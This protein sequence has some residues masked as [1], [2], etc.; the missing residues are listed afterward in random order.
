[1]T[2]A[3]AATA[4]TP[5]ADG[6]SLL[7]KITRYN[8]TGLT[9]LPPMT[10]SYLADVPGQKGWGTG[11]PDVPVSFLFKESTATG[12]NTDDHG[13]QIAD[14]NRDGLPDLIQGFRSTCG[15]TPTRKAWL[16]TGTTWQLAPTGTWV[17]PEDFVIHHCGHEEYETGLRL[18]DIN[19][20][21]FLDL[22]QSL[23]DQ[24][25]GVTRRVWL[26]TGTTWGALEPSGKWALPESFAVLESNSST[27]ISSRDIGVRFGDV[28]GDGLVDLVRGW[29]I[30]SGANSRVVYLLDPTRGWVLASGWT[31]PLNFVIHVYGG[32]DAATGTNLIDVNGDGMAD[33][34]RSV[35]YEGTVQKLLYL[36]TG[37][38]F[39]QVTDW[40]IPDIFGDVTNTQN[41]SKGD[42]DSDDY[43]VRFADVN[44]DG[45]VDMVVARNWEGS[46]P[47][48]SAPP[49]TCQR[50]LLHRGG[51]GWIEDP[52]WAST[53][54]S[55]YFFIEH[56][57]G[58][59]DY[60]DGVRLT[61]IDGNGT[62][63]LIK[64]M[65]GYRGGTPE[66]RMNSDGFSDLLA[67]LSNGVGGGTT[68]AYA[69]SATF[70]TGRGG[71]PAGLG[72]IVPVVTR[73]TQSDGL[74]SN[75]LVSTFGYE[76][77]FY[78]YVRREF[79]GFRYVRTDLPGGKA[80]T[81]QL[82]L[83]DRTRAVAPLVGSVERL[84]SRRASD[85]T[86][87]SFTLNTY[88][89][90]DA[91]LTYFHFLEASDQYLYDFGAA[92]E[93][94][95]A[96]GSGSLKHTRAVYAYARDASPDRLIASRQ[97]QLKGDAGIA[98]DDLTFTEELINTTS[99]T[100][101]VGL[102]K[103]RYATP[104]L[105]DTFTYYDK[106]PYGSAGVTGAATKI[107]ESDLTRTTPGATGNRV[108]EIDYD[109]YGHVTYSKDGSG[110]EM[111]MRY[112]VI[113]PTKT[114]RDQESVVTHGIVDPSAPPHTTSYTYDPRFG[115]VTSVGTP[116]D[117][118][119]LFTYDAFG[120][121][122]KTWID[123]GT[124]NRPFVCYQY[125]LSSR[126]VVVTRFERDSYLN[127]DECGPNGM[128]G[129]ASFFDGLGRRLQT[130]TEAA[131]PGAS[132]QTVEAMGFDTDGRLK[133]AWQPYFT[134]DALQTYTATPP[135]TA[136][137]VQFSYD[138]VGRPVGLT[139]PGIPAMTTT[140]S[141]WTR[142]DT[143]PEGKRVQTDVDA[144]GRAVGR[145]TYDAGTFVPGTTTQLSYDPVGRLSTITDTG[146]NRIVHAYD[147]FGQLRRTDD[148]DAGTTLRD[149]NGDGTLSQFTDAQG[150][151]T[152]YAYDELHRLL[153][154]TRSDK[155][156]VTYGY[157][158]AIGRP[159][160]A[161][162]VDHATSVEDSASGVR[163]EF[164]YDNMGRLSMARDRI[165]GTWYEVS[166]TLD[167]MGRTELLTYPDN[168]TA[169]Y[170]YRPDGRVDHL[171]V[172]A[173]FVASNVHYT[174]AGELASATLGNGTGLANTFDGVTSWLTRAQ[175]TQFQSW[176]PIMD[177]TF[178]YT[179]SGHLASITDNTNPAQPKVQTFQMDG[180]Y[181]LTRATSPAT[182]GTLDYRY[183]ALGNLT[184]KEGVTFNYGNGHPHQASSTSSGLTFQY[185][186]GGNLTQIQDTASG[187]VKTYAYDLDG[188]LSYVKEAQNGTTTKESWY[189][190]DPTGGRVKRID[191]QGGTSTTTILIGDL[192]EAS[193]SGR[194]A[195]YLYLGD[196][197]VAVLTNTVE[198]IG[199][200]VGDRV[201]SLSA[202]TDG[203]GYVL[204]RVDY[205]PYG[206]VTSIQGSDYSSRFLFAGSRSEAATGLDD[207]GARFYSPSLGR[208]LSVD[209]L[210]GNPLDPRGLNPY[211][212]ALGN[213][214]GYADVGGYI[215]WHSVAKMA[216]IYL[217]N[218]YTGC[219][220]AC[221]VAVANGV[222]EGYEAA[223]A[224]GKNPWTGSVVG[225]VAAYG[226]YYV[227]E[228]AGAG[229]GVLGGVL[230]AGASTATSETIK[231]TYL[232]SDGHSVLRDSL[233]KA[234]DKGIDE[235][236][237][238]AKEDRS[239]IL[240]K[241]IDKVKSYLKQQAHQALDRGE[242]HLNAETLEAAI[243][244]LVA[245]GDAALIQGRGLTAG[246]SFPLAPAAET[247]GGLVG[248]VRPGAVDPFGS[249]A[250]GIAG[251]D[252]VQARTRTALERSLSSAITASVLAGRNG[253]LYP[254]SPGVFG[255]S[256][257]SD[258]DAV[259]V[260]AIKASE[261]HALPVIAR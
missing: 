208:F 76:G 138:P 123:P 98:T 78:H 7:T 176:A 90:S 43:G 207:F 198:G 26:S 220:G 235:Y 17:L 4:F 161:P 82:F 188:R 152:T 136:V 192:Y 108:T 184:F 89:E 39:Q 101:R 187:V 143:D 193:L 131:E 141:V 16:N 190:Y 127:G 72:F 200:F 54:P 35:R 134:T 109:A 233:Q 6:S 243:P 94:T 177:S 65:D 168:A 45:L 204:S 254:I 160:G 112:G 88:N 165:D 189:T 237:D 83:Q 216:I 150:R 61:D 93:I 172:A 217:L 139:L 167:T 256:D 119:R 144:Y 102:I 164:Q 214:V 228:K 33:I 104:L 185:D 13:V 133:S 247:G 137:A 124:E 182:Y 203:Y 114:F 42:E 170:F 255:S 132:S 24:N 212:Y 206:E 178:G 155:S 116:A 173:T 261:S 153:R 197:R 44:G 115:V 122:A 37:S 11:I 210:L 99:T 128:L 209:P 58:D 32:N 258:L 51:K 40:D 2:P 125:N 246:G 85:A 240:Q 87:F 205:K 95:T 126:P 81:E 23:T 259:G 171:T 106:Q 226:G 232:K 253:V 215:N 74:T 19:N 50:V 248:F 12:R 202:V 91:G 64:A 57:A 29:D 53:I 86:V 223:D 100:W 157:D 221:A 242:A 48:C 52:D 69:S 96:D 174:A 71:A 70:P 1:M 118:Q 159:Y 169:Q 156:T 230:K 244:P 227:G 181:R 213:P 201:G 145:R 62:I 154:K 199:Y 68:L 15:G 47:D 73:I 229:G 180:L 224:E 21:G 77:G 22:V 103:R 31:V 163:Q 158:E 135:P 186:A 8:G 236:A 113:D 149:Y 38:S 234:I 10:F 107:E 194:N 105:S 5:A 162:P 151:I 30:T 245:L 179:P 18:L 36:S 218:A 34:I 67:G 211:A 183:D 146:G 147:A 27:G 3:F 80:Y 260:P 251:L 148:P 238:K 249:G 196:H 28:N 231:R 92:P 63:D 121:L 41:G 120:R 195:K 14:I 175:A 46:T 97:T 191:A 75:D 257:G 140:Y 142:E 66:R 25:G 110:H 130:K 84:A 117:G 222:V 60:D 49:A 225:G 239:K 59:E 252:A 111:T 79:R 166:Q 56:R 9:S 250:A 241:V 129:T 55:T 20:D 219:K